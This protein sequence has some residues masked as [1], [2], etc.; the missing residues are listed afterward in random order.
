MRNYDLLDTFFNYTN[1]EEW[2]QYIQTKI[3][4]L[5]K[6]CVKLL[7][8]KQKL[9]KFKD[10]KFSQISSEDRPILL[11][12]IEKD[13]TYGENSLAFFYKDFFGLYLDILAW[14]KQEEQGNSLL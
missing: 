12:G 3:I 4:P 8:F 2:T 1:R 14:I 10:K 9:S 7:E 13:G 6:D 11:G 5:W